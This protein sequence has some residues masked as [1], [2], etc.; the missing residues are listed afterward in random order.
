MLKK[1]LIKLS[2]ISLIILLNGCGFKVLDKS[3]ANN[4]SIK[5]IITSGDK[6]INYKITNNLFIYS[7]KKRQNEIILYLDTKKNNIIK[8]KNI[9]NEI[10]KYQ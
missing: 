9:K 2:F 1:K 8:E 6:R 5:E 3:D 7:K 10:T 4:F